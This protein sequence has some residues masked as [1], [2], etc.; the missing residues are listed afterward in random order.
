MGTAPGPAAIRVS[1]VEDDA[2]IRVELAALLSDTPG[3]LLVSEHDTGSDAIARI[4]QV[5]PEVVL[6]DINLPGMTGIECVRLLKRCMPEIQV[7]MLTI[8][9]DSVSIFESLKAGADG[10]L[11]KRLPG[12]KLIEA[13]H[14]ARN[15]GAPMSA[16]IARKVVKYFNEQDRRKSELHDLSVREREVLKELAEGRPYKEIATTLNVSI[17]TVRKHLQSVYQKLHVHNRT[18]A[19]VKYLQT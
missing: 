13:I 3:F 14:D 6:M 16:Q 1:V 7:L 17:D 9:E 10:Y 11:L 19:V 4:P 15:G 8:Y 12:E 5:L 2:E 18:E